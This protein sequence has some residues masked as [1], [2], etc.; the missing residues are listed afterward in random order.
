MIALFAKSTHLFPWPKNTCSG[1]HGFASIHQYYDEALTLP[2]ELPSDGP[3]DRPL[4]VNPDLE[5]T[6]LRAVINDI[7][8]YI[9]VWDQ[10]V[11]QFRGH[12]TDRTTQRESLSK[13]LTK[14]DKD[15][16][17]HA[18]IQVAIAEVFKEH[19]I[20]ETLGQSVRIWL[21]HAVW[22]TIQVCLILCTQVILPK[23]GVSG[24][25]SDGPNQFNCPPC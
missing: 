9:P 14:L 8:E 20:D 3:A 7:K 13:D 19:D 11:G 10:L 22:I 24:L 25:V 15:E 12:K 21:T 6:A 4:D 1:C 18:T 5:A 23:L 2:F 17:S 16:T